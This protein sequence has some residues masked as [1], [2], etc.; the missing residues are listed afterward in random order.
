MTDTDNLAQMGAG[1]TMR[2]ATPADIKQIRALI[3]EAIDESPFYNAEFKAHEKARLNEGFLLALI[4]ADPWF[5]PVILYKNEFAGFIISTPELGVLWAVWVY[6]SPRFRQTAIALTSIGFLVR[7]WD[8]GRFH[9]ISCFVRP[10]NTRSEAVMTH[11]GF[12]RTV[13]LRHHIFG[14]D[15]LLLERPLNKATD[16]YHAPLAFGRIDAMRRK[17]RQALRRTR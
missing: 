2:P 17:L 1:R 10:E 13:L 7:H 5:L 6:I 9:K 8:N 12:V 14:Q 11:F 3:C 15:Y 16:G 4:A